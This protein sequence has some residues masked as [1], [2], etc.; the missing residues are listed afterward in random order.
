M[1]FNQRQYIINKGNNYISVFV[2]IFC[3]CF[4]F[5]M[6]MFIAFLIFAIAF[7]LEIKASQGNDQ[8]SILVISPE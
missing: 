2:F 4:C 1:F 6:I 5:V 3:F 8:E 7:T